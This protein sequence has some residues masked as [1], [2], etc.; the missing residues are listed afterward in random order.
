[1]SDTISCVW[2]LGRTVGAVSTHKRWAASS[3][4]RVAMAER[5]PR[6]LQPFL[7]WLTARPLTGEALVERSPLYFV[8]VA[9]LQTFGGVALAA[10]SMSANPLPAVALLLVGWLFTSAGLGLFQVVVFHHCS[11]STVF[12]TR[13]NNIRVG[14]LISAI[15]LFKHFDAYKAEHMLH[16][17]HKM[18][19]TEEDEFAGF[20][21][22]MCRL[23]PALPKRILWRRVL[24]NLVSP[25]FHLRFLRRRL[26]GAWRS[27]D[28]TH[29]AVGIAVWGTLAGV[30]VA[31]GHVGAF[32][33]AWVFPVVVLLQVATVFRIL[34][35]HRF[36]EPEMILARGKDFASHATAGVFPGS[37]PPA[38]T[39]GSA[40]GIA[41][42][43]GWW[44]NMLTVQ[45]LVRL[46]VLV[47]DAPCH[48]F[49][50]R[51]PASRRW[52]SYIQARQVDLEEGKVGARAHYQEAWGLFRAI[53][54]NLASLSRTPHGL[55]G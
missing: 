54:E 26:A 52:T 39:I 44:S 22:G 25:A 48:D 34:C 30:A 3:D 41:C 18:L 1:M 33:V 8:G 42:W 32:L 51:R 2:G 40:T 36:P 43:I 50:H 28:R 47:G 16:H 4:P 15:L 17:N 9:L 23:Q 11:H 20:V 12:R 24:V 10:L 29:N 45:L 14:R 21:F 19:L 37:A 53:D 6:S 31:T 35:E 27:P 7:T 46:F 13:E 49:H 5:L 38:E 55:V